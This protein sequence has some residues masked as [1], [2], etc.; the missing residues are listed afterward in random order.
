M[1]QKGREDVRCIA[2]LRGINVSGKRNL[3]MADVREIFESLSFKHVQTYAQ[4]GNVIFDCES[5]DSAKF[6]E[7]IEEKLSEV[8][9]VPLKVIIRT[10]PELEAI[11]E[12]NPLVRR[13][14][15]VPD[16]LYITFL[17]DTPDETVVSKIDVT[18]GQ[19]E[20][21]EIDGQEVYLYCPNGYAH[22]KLSNAMFEAKLKTVATTRNWRTVKKL[23]A[24]ST[25]S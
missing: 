13:A 3:K 21:F 17:S 4:S 22:T 11:V 2:L 25:L 10:R 15:A 5:T 12:N 18:P 6:A 16:K 8:L 19:A 20:M 24:L 9:G 23:L 14:S 1:K 7:C